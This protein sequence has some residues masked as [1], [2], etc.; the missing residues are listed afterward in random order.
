MQC[1][2]QIKVSNTFNVVL[3]I[4]A[5]NYIYNRVS[6]LSYKLYLI[7]KSPFSTGTV[8]FRDGPETLRCGGISERNLDIKM[9]NLCLNY[10]I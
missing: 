2:V 4:E 10:N 8:P 3:A 6:I 5:I 7:N 9:R 1:S